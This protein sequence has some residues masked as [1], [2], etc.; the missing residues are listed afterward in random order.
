MFFFPLPN[1]IILEILDRDSRRYLNARLSNNIASLKTGTTCRAA[2]LTPQGRTEGVFEVL[3]RSEE[4]YLLVC[5]EGDR[6]KVIAAL[7]RY[8]VADRVAVN[9]R[10]N[11]YSLIHLGGCPDPIVSA[12]CGGLLASRETAQFGTGKDLLFYRRPRSGDGGI[13]VL[14]SR[15]ISTDFLANLHKHAVVEATPEEQTLYRIKAGI[16]AFPQELNE[17]SLLVEGSAEDLISRDKGCYVG[18]EVVERVSAIGKV[19][20]KLRRIALATITNLEGKEQVFMDSTA[21]GNVVSFARDKGAGRTYC[22]AFVKNDPRYESGKVTV[23]EVT[24]EFL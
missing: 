10:S 2:A 8:I 11:E 7:R 18:Q 12:V 9:D 16:P 17:E 20:R 14:C 19:P 3:Q 24:G 5:D 1:A 13:D 21:V 23:A 6:E 4:D 15:T 22:F